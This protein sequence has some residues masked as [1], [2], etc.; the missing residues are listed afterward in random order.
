MI[1]DFHKM[2]I[3]TPK[4]CH[5]F[6]GESFHLFRQAQHTAFGIWFSARIFLHSYHHFGITK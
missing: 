5:I 6:S 4:G 2:G 1:I 3:P